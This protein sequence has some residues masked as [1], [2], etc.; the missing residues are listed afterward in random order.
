VRSQQ[1]SKICPSDTEKGV[2]ERLNRILG[3]VV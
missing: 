1:E 3:S 2:K